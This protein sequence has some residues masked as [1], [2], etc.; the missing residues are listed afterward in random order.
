MS[1]E[2]ALLVSRSKMERR[3]LPRVTCMR[4]VQEAQGIG[5]WCLSPPVLEPVPVAPA[6]PQVD[7][8]SRLW[9]EGQSVFA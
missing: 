9:V 8:L 6:H 2:Y 5:W 3:A 1:G 7:R 4:A